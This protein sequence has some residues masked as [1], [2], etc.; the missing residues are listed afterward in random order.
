MYVIS[1]IALISSYHYDGI[2]N[3]HLPPISLLSL[4]LPGNAPG[5]SSCATTTKAGD[6]TWMTRQAPEAVGYTNSEST[7]AVRTVSR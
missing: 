7:E 2:W 1:Q 3:G 6:P 4:L 5:H